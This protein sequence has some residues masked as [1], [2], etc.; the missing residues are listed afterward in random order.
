MKKVFLLTCVL[1]YSI[2]ADVNYKKEASLYAEF[3]VIGR[4][5]VARSLKK[6]H[7]NDEK[8]AYKGFESSVFISAINNTFKAK[9]GIDIL[10]GKGDVDRVTID[11]L[12]ILLDASKK[13][14]DESQGVIN[15]AGV[16]FKGFI[17]AS[18]GK[19]VGDILEEKRGIRLKQTSDKL[20]NIYNAPDEFEKL[21]MIQMK[22]DKPVAGSYVI[23]E[24]I[25]SYR[26]LRPIY[27]QKECL[28]CHGSPKGE[29][30]ITGRIKEGYK[31]GELRG[32]ISISIPKRIN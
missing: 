14:V 23:K 16:G 12:K 21:S 28:K 17:P 26:L 20:R 25:N 5:E 6:Y 2:F 4:A 24:T 18:Y 27:I 3:L 15:M 31:L 1:L 9:T 8:R 32:L 19:Y 13:I 22:L 7:I 11:N 30:D 29:K 10:E